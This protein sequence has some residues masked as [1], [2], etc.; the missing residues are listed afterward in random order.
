MPDYLP[1]YMNLPDIASQYSARDNVMQLLEAV[2]AADFSVAKALLHQFKPSL[3]GHTA[4]ERL[5]KWVLLARDNILDIRHLRGNI[6]AP[7]RE[8][9]HTGHLFYRVGQ[10][11]NWVMQHYW[12]RQLVCADIVVENPDG[13]FL[14]KGDIPYKWERFTRLEMLRIRKNEDAIMLEGKV[15]A[16]STVYKSNLINVRLY[17]HNPEPVKAFS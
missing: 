8:W 11:S 17:E 10:T 3:Q 2:A 1:S 4:S 5:E 7:K 14:G 6:C 16:L 15:S 12:M 13:I 9:A